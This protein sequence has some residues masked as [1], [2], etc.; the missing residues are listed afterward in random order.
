MIPSTL[1]FGILTFLLV[2]G[3]LIILHELGHFFTAKLTRTKVVEFGFGFPPRATG[4][5]T[6]RTEV[7]VTEETIFEGFEE[8]ASAVMPALVGEGSDDL[9]DH[10]LTESDPRLAVLEPGQQIEATVEKRADGSLHALLIRP[11]NRRNAL[12]SDAG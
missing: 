6:G 3:P 8:H 1:I 9:R 4:L 12:A 2:L 10:Q 5:W 7:V 11:K